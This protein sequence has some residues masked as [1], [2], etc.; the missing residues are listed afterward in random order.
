MEPKQKPER[1]DPRTEA[2]REWVLERM[3]E[4]YG[5]TSLQKEHQSPAVLALIDYIVDMEARLEQWQDYI[6]AEME[7][8]DDD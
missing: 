4:H 8:K 6:K 3:R 2:A 1:T 7:R 5:T